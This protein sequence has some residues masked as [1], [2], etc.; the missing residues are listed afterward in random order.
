MAAFSW[1][2]G[3]GQ[4]LLQGG[5]G[6]GH[7]V[8]ADE[9][10]RHLIVGVGVIRVELDGP[11]ET[12]Q[13]R[14]RLAEIDLAYAQVVLGVG[15]VGAQPGGL[16]VERLRLGELPGLGQGLADLLV[17]AVAFGIE[18]D[19]LA[20]RRQRLFGLAG[21]LQGQAEIEPVG[22]VRR[23]EPDG[24]TVGGL[25]LGEFLL[26][27]ELVAFQECPVCFGQGLLHGLFRPAPG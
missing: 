26:A 19:G 25:G 14:L 5:L 18:L 24:L 27:V 3:Q 1:S 13:S 15:V 16:F 12:R 23:V 6:F 8:L 21:F 7:F 10:G 11:G 2:G 4:E 20:E 17:G 9:D 22:P